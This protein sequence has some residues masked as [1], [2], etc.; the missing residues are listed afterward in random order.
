MPSVKKGFRAEKCTGISD[1]SN[2][3]YEW[4]LVSNE[5]N[6]I[7][8]EVGEIN[9]DMITQITKTEVQGMWRKSNYINLAIEQD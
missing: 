8:V 4:S 2:E 5:K 1:D 6:W 7:G 3:R 9:R